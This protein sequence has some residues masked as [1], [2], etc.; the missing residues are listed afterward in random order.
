MTKFK[1]ADL[2]DEHYGRLQ[3]SKTIFYSY[4]KRPR[5]SGKIET[6]KVFEDNVLFLEALK[7]VSP[8]SIVVVDGEGSRNC[9]LMGD[10]LAGIVLLPGAWQESSL[11]DAYVIQPIL[12]I[13]ISGFLP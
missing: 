2:C 11:M 6:V 7:S 1:T 3:I 8:G 12:P 5:F 10:R 4:G 13:L 9:A